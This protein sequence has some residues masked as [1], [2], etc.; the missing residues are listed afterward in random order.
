MGKVYPHGKVLAG[1]Y[2]DKEVYVGPYRCDI[3]AKD[4]P[5]GMT[6][7]IE[8][9]LEATNHEHLGKTI[10]Y[11]SGLGAK[12]IVW[13]VK[14]AKEEHR[15]AVEW[16]N[17]NTTSEVNFFLIEIHAYK[18]GNS[19]PAP[20]F[21]VIEKPNDFVKISKHLP[22][23]SEMNKSESERL[24]FWEQFNQVVLSK[25]KPFNL[26]KPTADHWYDVAVGTSECKLSIELVNKDSNVVVGL[27]I[28][29][30]KDLFDQLYDH[31]DEIEKKL[32]FSLDWARLDNKKA[33]RIKYYID[34]LDFNNHSN[35]E[36][37][38]NEI[39]DIAVKMRDVFKKYI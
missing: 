12:V 33:S 16:L 2:V 39:I 36:K 38:M 24:Y 29:D 11:A 18:I 5:T 6:V 35:Y 21:E 28:K 37:L 3:V 30:N 34:G 27:L 10:T 25:G 31:K 19:D 4:E 32:G 20:K 9:Q 7:I 17:N 14:E 23:K 8:N 22:N 13:I 15:A 26:R 1:K